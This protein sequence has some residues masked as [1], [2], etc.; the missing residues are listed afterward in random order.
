MKKKRI[1]FALILGFI[2]IMIVSFC[3]CR[4]DSLFEWK[5]VYD[6]YTRED[7][8]FV[9]YTFNATIKNVE[10][11]IQDK[12]RNF[13]IIIDSEDFLERYKD[14]P[15]ADAEW[16]TFQSLSFYFVDDSIPLLEEAGFFEDIAKDT[17]ITITANDYIG[18]DGWCYPVFGVEINGKTYLD[19]D[20]G[21]KNVINYVQERI[22]FYS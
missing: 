1:G 14:I 3:G 20:T 19:F 8:R 12:S 9:H 5:Q 13:K 6:A 21:Y 7:D 17:A 10:E 22:E 11:L 4:L 16:R 15:K 2:F 18:W